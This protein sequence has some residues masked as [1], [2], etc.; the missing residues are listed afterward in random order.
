MF[1][2]FTD[3][4]ESRFKFRP[5]SDFPVPDH[6]VKSPKTYPSKQVN[7]QSKLGT[8]GTNHS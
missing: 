5:P 8:Q 6:F 7:R 1:F 4:F 3:A 2:C